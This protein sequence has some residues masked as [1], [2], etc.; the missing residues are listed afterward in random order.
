MKAGARA[1]LRLNDE[2]KRGKSLVSTGRHID[3]SSWVSRLPSNEKDDL[4]SRRGRYGRFLV[5]PLL[6][7]LGS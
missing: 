7:F 5:T 3:E 2:D 4:W 1:G 6:H